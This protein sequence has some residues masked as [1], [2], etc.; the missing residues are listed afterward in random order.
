MPYRFSRFILLILSK[1][2]FRIEFKGR[3]FIPKKGGFILV[4]NHTSYLD[5]VALGVACTRT[6]RFMAKDN[7]FSRHFLASWLKAVGVIPVKRDA[8]DLSALKT[9]IKS[10]NLGMGLA[11]FPE[12]TRRLKENAFINP[13]PGVG[14]LAAK[15]RLPIIPAYISGTYEALPKGAKSLNFSKI[16][17][18]FGEQINIE[19]GKPYHDIAAM[20]M[21]S[22]KELSEKDN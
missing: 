19:R 4:A 3:E 1:L 21:A 22:V 15:L 10:G 2:F 11:L 17:V 16:K 20:I 6:L 5:P 8:A 7:L 18:K 14:F 13:E 9:A 12:G